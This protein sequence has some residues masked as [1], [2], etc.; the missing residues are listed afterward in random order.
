[1][2]SGKYFGTATNYEIA[3]DD[4]MLVKPTDSSTICQ[5]GMA[6]KEGHVGMLS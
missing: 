5:L 1:L 3:F 2:K 4:M 6:F